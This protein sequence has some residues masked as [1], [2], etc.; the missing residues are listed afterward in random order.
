MRS[1]F[2]SLASPPLAQGGLALHQGSP[3]LLTRVTGGDCSVSVLVLKVLSSVLKQHGHQTDCF[4]SSEEPDYY[5]AVLDWQPDI[6]GVYATTGQEAWAHDHIVRWKK[7]LPHLKAV[8]AGRTPR[9]TSP[10]CSTATARSSTP[11]SRPRRVA[12][13]H[14]LTPFP[15]ILRSTSP[16]WP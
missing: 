5:Q 2:A 10:A 13:N 4:L 8:M 16:D 3:K 11:P 14:R 6:V 15:N 9:T 12:G 7:E 1:L